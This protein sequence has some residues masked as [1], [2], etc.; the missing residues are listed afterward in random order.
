MLLQSQPVR[1]YATF[2]KVPLSPPQPSQRQ[3]ASFCSRLFL[4]YAD[5]MMRIGNQRQLHQDDLLEL[6]DDTRSQVA[7]EKFKVQFDRHDQSILRTVVHTYGWKFMLL[8]LALVFS[9][10]CNLFAPVVLHHVIDAFTAPE[11]DLMSLSV[12]LAPFFASRLVN[13]LVSPHASFQ[14]E[15]IV[16]RLGVSLKALLFEKAMRCSVQSR[17]DDKA[18]DLANIYTS[19]VDRV[20]QCSNDINT[21]WILPIQIGVAVYMLYDVL[22]L[23]AFA[24]LAAIALSMIM[25][26]PFT[27]HIPYLVT[28]QI[29]KLVT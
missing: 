27:G 21:L 11:V 22:G 2:A 12:W 28:L 17:S 14:A 24:G 8:G 15:L 6:D 20:V 19:D 3:S 4:S 23:A 9:T 29:D 1:E 16:F 25:I 10:A 26:A 7:Y 5:D 13:A 18:V